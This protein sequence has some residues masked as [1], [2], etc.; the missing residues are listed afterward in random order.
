MHKRIFNHV[1]QNCMRVP[2]SPSFRT[3]SQNIFPHF[4]FVSVPSRSIYHHPSGA[5]RLAISLDQPFP[6]QIP[7]YRN[8]CAQ[9]RNHN[10]D[11]ESRPWCV[12]LAIVF[13]STRRTYPA[14]ACDPFP[15]FLRLTLQFVTREQIIDSRHT[16]TLHLR[17]AFTSYIGS[18]KPRGRIW[19][20]PSQAVISYYWATSANRLKNEERSR[21]RTTD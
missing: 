14:R 15:L 10:R 13:F 4:L 21:I 11:T 8:S 17:F 20:H 19:R 6:M 7:T 18:W 3:N 16:A 12:W 5:L 1:S 2:C 9:I